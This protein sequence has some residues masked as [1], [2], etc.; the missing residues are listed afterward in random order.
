MELSLLLEALTAAGQ[1]S[2]TSSED[3]RKVREVLARL[4]ASAPADWRQLA[5]AQMASMVSAFDEPVIFG[6]GGGQGAGKSTLAA[7]LVLAAEALDRRAISVSLDDFYLT[8]SERQRLGEEVHPLLATRGVPGTHD[9]TLACTTLDGLLEPGQVQVPVFDKSVDDRDPAARAVSGPFDLVVFEGWCVGAAAEP[10]GRLQDPINTL[11]R[12]ED[13][14]GRWRNYVNHTLADDYPE[15]WRR[16][17]K[18]LFLKVPDLAAVI[19]WRT[20]QEQAHPSSRRMPAEAIERFVA[21]YERLT[22]WMA[23]A[24]ADRADLLAILDN[25]HRLAELLPGSGHHPGKTS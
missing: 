15:L 11:E 23:E 3:Q 19:R 21:H 16:L 9:L 18:L 22:R 13:R 7:Q 20:E 24:M 10:E 14:E 25:E 1:P 17:Q 4:P 6:I 8:R 2:L 12:E 5:A